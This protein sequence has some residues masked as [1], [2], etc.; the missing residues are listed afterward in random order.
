MASIIYLL[1]ALV[2]ASQ[3]QAWGELGH[4]TVG[5]LAA[6]YFSTEA[7]NMFNDLVKPTDTFDISD[8]AVWADGFGTQHRMP[9]SKPMHFIDAKD[10]PPIQCKVNFN[11]DCDADKKCVVSA[12]ANLV[13]RLPSSKRRAARRETNLLN[14]QSKS[15]IRIWRARIKVMH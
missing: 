8:G 4:R 15:T 13:S 1:F 10:D 5:Y 3:V 14:R 11:R 12:I 9:W 2:V 7:E 6:L